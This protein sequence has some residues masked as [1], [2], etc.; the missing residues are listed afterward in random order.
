MHE[1]L[2]NIRTRVYQLK[3]QAHELE[4]RFSAVEELEKQLD[5]L[6][7]DELEQQAVVREAL[8]KA[9]YQLQDVARHMGFNDTVIMNTGMRVEREYQK[10]GG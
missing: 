7:P 2:D 4:R 9:W 10:P 1:R 6:F 3:S 8:A 5:L